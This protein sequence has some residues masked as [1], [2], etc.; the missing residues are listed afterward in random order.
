VRTITVAGAP[1]AVDLTLRPEG[2]I[3]GTVVDSSG[4]PVARAAIQVFNGAG[5]ARCA[6]WEIETDVTGSFVVDSMAPA[7]YSVSARSQ[8]RRGDGPWIEVEAGRTAATRIV[9][10]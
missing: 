6:Y 3:A 2:R 7:R 5:I 9:I 10:P 1:T 8:G 4:A